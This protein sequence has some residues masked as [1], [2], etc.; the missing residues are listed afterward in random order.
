MTLKIYFIYINFSLLYGGS[1][2]KDCGNDYPAEN[3]IKGK[4]YND[5]NII[6]IYTCFLYDD[7]IK[8]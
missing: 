7:E 2:R 4:L 1:L 8:I 6:I 5:N 3:N